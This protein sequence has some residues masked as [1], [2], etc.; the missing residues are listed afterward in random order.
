MVYIFAV[1]GGLTLLLV[2]YF[3]SK[4]RHPFFTGVSSA[5]LGAGGLAAVNLLAPVTGVALPANLV[6]GFVA[7]V[8]S[9]PGVIALLL[10]KFFWRV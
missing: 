9:L 8:L 7:A 4:T 3:A 10:I 2:S 5:V 6:T 1:G